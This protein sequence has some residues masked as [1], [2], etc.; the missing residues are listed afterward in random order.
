MRQETY[1]TTTAAKLAGLTFRQVSVWDMD[2]FIQPSGEQAH[3]TGTRRRYTFGDLVA[4]RTAAALLR[5]GASLLGLKKA[6]AQLRSIANVHFQDAFLIWSGDDILW[7][8][9]EQLISMLRQP[10]QATLLIVNVSTIR[11]ELHDMLKEKAA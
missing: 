3:G 4:L 9:G 10:G 5:T 8:D 11:G 6:A 7:R 2:H 1:S